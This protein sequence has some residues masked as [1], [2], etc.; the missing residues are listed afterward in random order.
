M[1]R[2]EFGAVCNGAK[3]KLNLLNNNPAGY[4]ISAMV[5]GMFIAFGGFVMCTAGAVLTANGSTMTK[6]IMAFSFASALSLV[7]MAGA[8]L[9][10]GNNFVMAAAA[11][12]KVI[13]WGEAIKVWVLCYIG[14]LV[15]SVLA[16]LVYHLTGLASGTTGEFFASTA[17]TKM[18]GTP[19]NLFFKAV[20]CNT[21]VCLAVWCATKLK[22]E[23]GKL[24]MIF[25][26]IF[27]FVFC[28]FEHSIANMSV[29]AVGLL[30]PSGVEG[31]SIAGYVSNLLWVTL[32]NMVGGICVVA[33]PYYIIQKD[34]NS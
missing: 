6:V 24:I 15:G 3:G 32:G 33:L 11:F 23:S 19:V 18:A 29:M 27:V 8:E 21:L 12:A 20:L 26:C 30:N 4:F 9:F 1:F 28:G 5:A 17:A 34:K 7:V 13:T 2:D 16:A 22:S 10:T 31:L 25:W 14:N